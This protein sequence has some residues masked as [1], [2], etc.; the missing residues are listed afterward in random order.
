MG[1]QKSRDA[2]TGTVEHAGQVVIH[3]F[4][5]DLSDLSGPIR[6]RRLEVEFLPVGISEADRFGVQ[7]HR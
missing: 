4:R 2:V 3:C 6:Q 5:A 1:D 7:A